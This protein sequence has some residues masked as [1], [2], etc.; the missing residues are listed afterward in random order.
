MCFLFPNVFKQVANL[1]RVGT[2]R[3][4]CL[5]CFAVMVGGGGRGRGGGASNGNYDNVAAGVT[6]YV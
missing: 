2:S 3:N 5:A 6:V 1:S 4:D